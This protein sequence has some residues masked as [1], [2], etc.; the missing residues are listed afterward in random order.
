MLTKNN[1]DILDHLLHPS[2]VLYKPHIFGRNP[3]FY[4]VVDLGLSPRTKMRGSEM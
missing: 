4:M 2:E 3:F 1:V